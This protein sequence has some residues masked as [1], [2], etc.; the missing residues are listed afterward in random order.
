MLVLGGHRDLLVRLKQASE[1]IAQPE[2]TVRLVCPLDGGGGGVAREHLVRPPAGKHHQIPL[3]SS[4]SQPPVGEGVTKPVRVH[5]GDARLGGPPVQHL[6]HAVRR[7]R[8]ALAEQ[9]A[10]RATVRVQRPDP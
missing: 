4:S 6:P 9:Q 3:L 1:A 7:H 5:V 10:S 2:S 8:P